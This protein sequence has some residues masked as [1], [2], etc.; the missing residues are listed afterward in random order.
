MSRFQ[1]AV[2]AR[3]DGAG[4]VE[5][6]QYLADAAVRHEQLPRDVARSHSLVRHIDDARAHHV[7]QRAPVDEHAAQLVDA[8]VL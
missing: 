1:A 6:S 3:F 5:A 8:A 4:L 2:R 7:R